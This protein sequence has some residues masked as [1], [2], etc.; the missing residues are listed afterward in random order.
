MGKTSGLFG[1]LG[2]IFPVERFGISSF[3]FFPLRFL[4]N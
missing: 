2:G 1:Y 3:I 4:A